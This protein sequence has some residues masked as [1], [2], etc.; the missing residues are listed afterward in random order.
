MSK[1]RVISLVPSWTETLIEAGVEVV[2]RS[3]YCIHPK[4]KIKEV[5]AVGGTKDLRVSRLD[6]L[7]A[8]VLLLDREEN[9]KSMSLATDLNVVDTHVE[10]LSDL[11]R[12]LTKLGEVLENKKL[13]QWSEEVSEVLLRENLLWKFDQIP[14]ALEWVTRP[15]QEL[16]HIV[17]VIW[18]DPWMAINKPTF[19]GSMIEKLGGSPYHLSIGENKYPEF[20][21]EDFARQDTLFMFSSE[22]YPFEKKKQLISELGVPAVLVNGESYS[23]FGIRSLRFLGLQYGLNLFS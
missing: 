5:P 8:D 21:L 1:P 20:K 7:D 3:R 15:H 2:G 19:I 4:E 23:W 9:T 17:Y 12:D 10:S 22:P 14:A 6:A 13:L 18:K 11:K 16:K